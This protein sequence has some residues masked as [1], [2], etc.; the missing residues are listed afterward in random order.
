MTTKQD[1]SAKYTISLKN[2]AELIVTN[3]VYS[4]T[5]HRDKIVPVLFSLPGIGKTEI[6]KH[7]L[8][9]GSGKPYDVE[10][11]DMNTVNAG[12]LAMPIQDQ[13]TK[14]VAYYLHP[15]IKRIAEIAQKPE[16][17]ERPV[18]LA[19]DEL[20]RA[21]ENFTRPQ[22][23]NLLLSNTIADYT[24]PENVFIVG[25]SNNSEESI[26]DIVL[27]NDVTEFD[28]ATTNRLMPLFID[29][30]ANDWLEYAYQLDDNNEP[31]VSPEIALYIESGAGDG[32]SSKSLL[33]S[34]SNPDLQNKAF[35]TP[36]SWKRLSAIIDNPTIRE[37][38]ELLAPSI[39]GQIGDE[40]GDK[41]MKWLKTHGTMIPVSDILEKPSLYPKFVKSPAEVVQFMMTAPNYIES[42]GFNK[43][44]ADNFLRLFIEN[45]T[46]ALDFRWHASYTNNRW[47]NTA[48]NMYEYVSS[49]ST[50][51]ATKFMNI[52]TSVNNR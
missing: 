26:N 2:A 48:P 30:N 46:T 21:D 41:F 33:Y 24:L 42:N 28:S 35:A 10:V 20:N 44:L 7:N 32:S 45:E 40:Q 13:E 19:L 1:N 6:V 31:N 9:D 3:A 51:D 52:R 39:V 25:M 43:K 36:R 50:K 18:F 17:K 8:L 16:N 37:H 27:S 15:Q 14:Q 34:P 23:L 12:S 29:I 4:L 49:A 38:N 5:H 22:L 47:Y 11:I